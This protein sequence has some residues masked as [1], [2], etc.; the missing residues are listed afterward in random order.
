MAIF[1][2]MIGNIWRGRIAIPAAAAAGT[3]FLALL[4]AAGYTGPDSCALKVLGVDAA[5]AARAALSVATPRA[6][7]VAIAAT[8]FS[9]HGQAV[10]VGS[11]YYEP[12]DGD[13]ALSYV[14]A[15]SGA[16]FDAQCVVCW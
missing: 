11:D 4:K 14:R 5:G 13:A 9:T 3:T 1:P 10:L 6:A 12:S 15:L 7:G 16:A 8:D 2:N